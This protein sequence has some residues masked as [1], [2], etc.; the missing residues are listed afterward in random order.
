LYSQRIG[1]LGEMDLHRII[2]LLETLGFALYHPALSWL[3]VERALGD[4]REHLGGELSI[5]LLQGIGRKSEA[6]EINIPVMK[7]CI[8][9]LAERGGDSLPVL[10]DKEAA[11]RSGGERSA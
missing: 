9:S 5:P 6:H 10:T 11:L 4:F 3:E 7:S 8:A 2:T 1:L